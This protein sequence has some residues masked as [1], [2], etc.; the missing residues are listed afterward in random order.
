MQAELRLDALPYCGEHGE[1]VIHLHRCE[2]YRADHFRNDR[3]GG[4]VDIL[5]PRPLQQRCHGTSQSFHRLQK[6]CSRRLRQTR[7][8]SRKHRDRAPLAQRIAV[9]DRDVAI[10]E[11]DQ[12]R[13]RFGFG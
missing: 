10:N 8:L 6:P 7:H 9:L 2:R 4:R 11:P 3:C 13:A 12:C 1:P 5:M